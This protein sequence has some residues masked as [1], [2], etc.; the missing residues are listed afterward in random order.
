[1]AIHVWHDGDDSD[2]MTWA[3]AFKSLGHTSVLGAA[4]GSDI[5]MASKN[6]TGQV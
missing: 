6:K 2:G 1:M 3:K 5:W 4:A